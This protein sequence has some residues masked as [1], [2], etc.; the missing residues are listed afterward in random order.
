MEFNCK[1]KNGKIKFDWTVSI[2][3]MDLK[4]DLFQAGAKI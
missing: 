3:I 4:K 1:F 2:K